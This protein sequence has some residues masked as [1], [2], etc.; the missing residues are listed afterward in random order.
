MWHKYINLTP[1][2]SRQSLHIFHDLGHFPR[3]KSIEFWEE[4][5]LKKTQYVTEV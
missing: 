1:F 2:Q 4:I 5:S 3:N